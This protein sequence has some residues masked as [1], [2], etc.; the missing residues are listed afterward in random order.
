MR[1]LPAEYREVL[2]LREIEDLSYREI[3]ACRR[4][5]HRHRDVAAGAR[6]AALKGS[7]WSKC[8]EHPRAVP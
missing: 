1:L 6:A 3:A 5:P 8:K 7:G 2:V 4:R